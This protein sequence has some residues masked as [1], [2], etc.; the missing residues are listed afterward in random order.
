LWFLALSCL[1]AVMVWRG[2]SEDER[3]NLRQV[4]SNLSKTRVGRT[5]GW[6]AVALRTGLGV[7]F[8]IWGISL[9]SRVSGEHGAAAYVLAGPA[10][11]SWV[12]SPCSRRGGSVPSKTCP[13]SGERVCAHRI[14]PTWR[15]TC[16]TQLCKHFP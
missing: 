3:E 14:A 11:S 6:R 10:L 16:T 2:A 13:W 4:S 7:I 15:H 12:S 9:M 1:E 8:V 5:D